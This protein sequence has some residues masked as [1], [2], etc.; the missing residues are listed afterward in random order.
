MLGQFSARLV[1]KLLLSHCLAIKIQ[2]FLF[3]LTCLSKNEFGLL[4]LYI[5]V[6]LKT[7]VYILAACSI[8]LKHWLG[9]N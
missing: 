2:I 8:I 9:T 7:V 5:A 4:M 6:N 3:H 1:R